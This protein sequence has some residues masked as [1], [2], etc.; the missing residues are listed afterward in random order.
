M[1]TPAN[2]QTFR[3]RVTGLNENGNLVNVTFHQVNANPENGPA[4]N[5]TAPFTLALPAE[6]ARAYF[7]GQEFT[8]TLTPA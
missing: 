6:E 7:P 5:Y 1:T 3:Y 8:L 2:T 4:I